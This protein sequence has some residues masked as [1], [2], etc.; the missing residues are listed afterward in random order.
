MLFSLS[1]NSIYCLF[2]QII[3]YNYSAE[4]TK[5][6]TNTVLTWWSC[7]YV[8]RCM[9]YKEPAK[10]QN[11]NLQEWGR[12]NKHGCLKISKEA[13]WD[14]IVNSEIAWVCLLGNKV[15]AAQ[16]TYHRWASGNNC[17]I[18]SNVFTRTTAWIS[19]E[20][21][22]HTHLQQLSAPANPDHSL[23]T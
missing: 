9:V 13:E 2:W 17:V 15:G 7:V 12:R 10:L 6:S 18:T 22:T 1:V 14:I 4:N 20:T 16:L 19:P 11:N 3:I 8:N 23:H 5:N 21:H